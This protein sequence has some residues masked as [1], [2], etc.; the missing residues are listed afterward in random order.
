M[1]LSKIDL[2]PKDQL[3]VLGVPDMQKLLS[4]PYDMQIKA[5]HTAAQLSTQISKYLGRINFEESLKKYA[6]AY[7]NGTIDMLHDS[8]ITSL[9]TEDEIKNE[10]RTAQEEANTKSYLRAMYNDTRL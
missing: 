6:D 2:A 10:T 1:S 9:K 7:I 8:C 5:L 4:M 3:L